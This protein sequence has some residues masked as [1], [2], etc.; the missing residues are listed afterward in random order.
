MNLRT[1]FLPVLCLIVAVLLP[2]RLQAEVQPSPSLQAASTAVDPPPRE[3]VT[4]LEKKWIGD[5]EGY[6]ERSLSKQP[7][8][9]TTAIQ[10]RLQQ[11]ASQTGKKTALVYL[12]PTPEFL[13]VLVVSP[14]GEPVLHLNRQASRDRLMSV[15]KQ[16]RRT[17]T[18]I[19]ASGQADYLPSSQQLYQ[20]IVKPVEFVLKARSIE[21]VIFCTGAGLRSLPFAALHDGKTFLIENYN[22]A[23]IPAF[24]LLDTNLTDLRQEPVLA[25]GASMFSNLT[26][27]PAV[28]LEL[29]AIT[30]IQGGEVLLN[31]EFTVNNVRQSRQQ[32]PFR[33]L[34]LATHAEFKAGAV[35]RSFIQLWNDRVRLSQLK[36]LQLQSPPIDLLVLS[37]CRTALGNQQA[38][39]G[40]A[41]MAVNA[42]VKSA[43]GSLWLV[44]D[45]GTFALMREFY[46]NLRTRRTRIE[47][48]RDAQVAL[49]NGN[50]QIQDGQLQIASGIR[51]V[52]VPRPAGELTLN[53]S[54]PY[55]WAAFVMVGNPW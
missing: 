27:L 44:D 33:I 54:H 4:K 18:D 43:L 30:Q 32:Q 35:S 3:L 11:I 53:L 34:H 48:L 41:G 49:L 47:A 38:E 31:Q 1:K 23:L 13:E 6:F 7:L 25:T 42:G 10:A 20:W 39:L 16:F 36:R 12:M 5:Y 14:D 29:Q 28:P 45:A 26:P 15:A 24:N 22:V 52:T 21:T 9:D 17:V 8:L 37:A 40:F 2:L 19:R 51:T 50:V 46:Q 55:Y